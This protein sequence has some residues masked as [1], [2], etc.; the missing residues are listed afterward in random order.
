MKQGNQILVDFNSRLDSFQV[1]NHS[2]KTTLDDLESKI[3][4]AEAALGLQSPIRTFFKYFVSLNLKV[5]ILCRKINLTKEKFLQAKSEEK[6][7]VCLE[8]VE[9]SK[10]QIQLDQFFNTE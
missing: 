3:C 7:K 1:L 6:S 4:D 8:N 2:F 5:R 9:P 10:Y